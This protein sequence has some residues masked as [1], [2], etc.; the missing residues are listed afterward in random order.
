M[1]MMSWLLTQ[2]FLCNK[3]KV[4]KELKVAIYKRGDMFEKAY[5]KMANRQ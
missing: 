5:R 4:M 1:K 2:D 3:M